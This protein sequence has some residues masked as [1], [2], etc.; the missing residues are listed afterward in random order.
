MAGTALLLALIA[1]ILG[2]E[3][4]SVGQFGFSNP[5]VAS[6]I[7]GI[8]LGN[9]Q[10]GIT[11]GITLQ[12]IWMGVVGIGAA[13][14]PDVVIGSVLAT[15]FAILTG[16]GAEV[17]LAIAVP[18]AI[19]AQ[20]LDIFVRTINSGLT[21]WAERKI[22]EGKV[23]AVVWANVA[24]II[25]MFLRSFLVVY[26][27]IYFGVDAVKSVVSNIPSVI[28]VGLQA[29]GGML[30]ALGF[31]MLLNMVGI[32]KLFP[33][34][35][36]G[37]VAATFMK[38]PLVGVAILGAAAAFLHDYFLY[39]D[40]PLTAGE[41]GASTDSSSRFLSKPELRKLVWRQFFLQSAWNF[42]RMQNL[43]WAFVV[44]PALKK[45]YRNDPEKLK[46]AVKRNLE[47]F[48]TQPYMAAPILGISLAMEEG[49]VRGEVAP[50]SISAFKVA[51]MGPLAGVGDSLFWMT[52]RP[53]CLGIGIALAQGG[54]IIGP[55]VSL[56][57][58]NIPHLW[59]RYYPFVKG[60]ELG[61]SFLATIKSGIKRVTESLSV[62]GMMVLGAM[63]A[64]MVS[65]S[66]KAT[67]QIGQASVG[68]QSVLDAI[69]P[70]LLPLALTWVCYRVLKKGTSPTK[71]LFT[72]LILGILG[73]LVG[74]F[75]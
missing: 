17:A 57:L 58:F 53:I 15:S 54:N 40:E 44:L 50:E 31:G 23:D 45:F 3:R 52:I 27:A 10:M 24:G 64:T 56:V 33:Y 34:F 73:A 63:T 49:V 74:F 41:V 12:L 19:A 59:T 61:V 1:G 11:I 29:A 2:V 6:T 25:L 69:L 46:A 38:V 14:P 62:L 9:V 66:T 48:N 32:P 75:K 4:L 72:L 51:T 65:I 16:Q 21:H 60:Y 5:L 8:A 30:P 18:V 26:P 43:G 55:I 20:T 28:T 39:R 36:V 47:F 68:L 42:E 7:V 71:V 37:F 35:F 70:N 22:D 67:L 13:V